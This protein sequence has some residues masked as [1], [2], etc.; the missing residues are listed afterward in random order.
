MKLVLSVFFMTA[1]TAGAGLNVPMQHG[2]SITTCADAHPTAIY[3]MRPGCTEWMVRKGK[4]FFVSYNSRGLRDKDYPP[5]KKPGAKRV[6]VSGPSLMFA[7]GLQERDT[8]VRVFERILKQR[9]LSVEA[10]NGGIDGYSTLQIAARMKEFLDAYRPDHVF[11]MFGSAWIKDTMY[12]GNSEVGESAVS[13]KDAAA[14]IYEPGFPDRIRSFVLRHKLEQT[15]RTWVYMGRRAWLSF[16]CKLAAEESGQAACLLGDSLM[17]LSLMKKWASASNAKFTILLFP[18]N[19]TNNAVTHPDWD[20]GLARI[21]EAI[22]PGIVLPFH[23]VT[24]SLDRKGLAYLV[25]KPGAQR[26][27]L[28]GDY[29][30]NEAGAAMFARDLADQTQAFFRAQ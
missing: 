24:Q 16:R 3:R 25:L 6:L 10:I 15:Y 28:P 26:N 21:F 8:P 13:T 5:E 1:G 7:P 11:L 17:L 9:K 14:F 18:N 12:F 30:F 27:T 22:T 20:L 23:G 19:L 4:K 2:D 29:H